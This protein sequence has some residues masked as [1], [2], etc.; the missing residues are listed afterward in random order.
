ML[1]IDL[2]EEQ[3]QQLGPLFRAVEEGNKRGIACA[4]GAQIWPDGIVVR[5]FD[6]EKL[7]VLARALGAKEG[8]IHDSAEDRIRC[9]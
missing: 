5:I 9:Q 1:K 8:V 3:K 7:E 6:G 4:I 2:S